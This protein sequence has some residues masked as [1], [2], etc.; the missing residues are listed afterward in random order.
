M[1]KA[2]TVASILISV[3]C[4]AADKLFVAPRETCSAFSVET[5][6][7]LKGTSINCFKVFN[8]KRELQ[9]IELKI[10]GHDK[11]GETITGN[12]IRIKDLDK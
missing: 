11:N 2:I 1:I 5:V 3:N 8:E 4:I 12:T 6:G 10:L 9:F 7:I